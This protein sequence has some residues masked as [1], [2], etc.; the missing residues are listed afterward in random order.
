MQTHSFDFSDNS[1]RAGFRLAALEVLNWGTFHKKIWVATPGGDNSLLTGDIGSGKSTLVDGLTTLLVPSQKITYN[2]AAGAETK[3]RNLTSYVRG[4]YK[5]A[6]DDDTLSA[7]AVALRDHNSYSVLLARFVNEGFDQTITLAQVFWSRDN[8]NTP[9]RFYLVARTPLSIAKHFSGFGSDIGDLKK[10]LKRKEH[11]KLFDSFSQ[12]QAEFRRQMGIDNDQALELLYQTV[13]MKSVGN[14]TEFVRSHMLESTDAEEKVNELS[15]QFDNL[16]RAHEA[17]LK[18]RQQIDRLAPMIDN[19]NQYESIESSI[20]ALRQ[21][22]EALYGFFADKKITLLTERIQRREQEQQKLESRLQELRLSIDDLRTTSRELERAIDQNGG[23]RLSEL[24]TELERLARERNRIAKACDDYQALCNILEFSPPADDDGFFH[25]R[26]Q[27]ETGLQSLEKQQADL[28]NQQVEHRVEFQKLRSQHDE[29]EA[30]IASLKSRQSNIPSRNLAIR[31][32]LSESLNLPESTLPF[33]GELLQV[34]EEDK[35]WEGAVERVLHNFALSLLVPDEHYQSVADYVDRTHLKG[36]LVYYRVRQPARATADTLDPRSLCRKVSIKTDS[37]FYSWLEHELSQRFDYICCD[38]LEDF[39]REVRAITT[40]GQIKS[41]GSRHEKDDRYRIDDRSR[42]VLG[43]SNRE[44]IFTLEATRKQ[45]EA[46]IQKSASA[47]MQFNQQINQLNQR[48]LDLKLLLKYAD[49]AEINWQPLA[50]QINSLEQEKQQLETGSDI[51]RTLRERLERC[52]AATG[53]KEQQERKLTRESGTAA[54]K[55][56]QDHKLLK[57]SE[58]QLSE[59]PE[60]ARESCFPTLAEMEQEALGDKKITIENCDS[61]QSTMRSWL[62]H[63]LDSREKKSRELAARITG[64]MADYKNAYPQET[65]EVDASMGSVAEFTAMLETLQGEDLPRHEQRFKQMLNEG[66]IHNM[67]MFQNWLDHQQ[68]TIRD[69]IATINRSLA[70][71]DYS[72]GTYIRLVA[73]NHR[74]PEINQ[75]KIDLRNCLGDTLTADNSDDAYAENK[76]L[77]VKTI[78]ERFNGREGQSELDKRWTRKV[79]DVRNW[80]L[81]NASERYREDDSEKEFYS[82]AGGKSGGQKEKLA[83]TILAAALA[84][85]LGLEWGENHS[86]SFR[87]VMIDEAFGRGSDE[88]AR[89]GLEL[90]R[91][92]NLQ[93]LIV[94]PLQKIHVIEDYV[95]SVHFVHNQGG[96]HSMLRNLTIEQYRQEKQQEQERLLQETISQHRADAIS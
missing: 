88:S 21:S 90:F 31:Q 72:D 67:A 46:D 68:Q 47:E 70:A 58:Q 44:K 42:F 75:F 7:K 56:K 51:L 48:Q 3:E 37:Q 45:L 2:K 19:C 71:I 53:E 10:K 94:T 17:V 59:L 64:Q 79:T 24:K 96:N 55:L 9:E 28:Q 50:I 18:A 91:R 95:N 32:A 76:F 41:G 35:H 86:R 73:D 81:F 65:R 43:W 39:R 54:E 93:L 38:Q 84:Y 15:R 36:R 69:K 63:R 80:F 6:K 13:S 4:Y 85:Q 60:T 83:Y 20:A 49:F 22:R 40:A 1:K 61:S 26:Q 29:L 11:I 57:F 89:Y 16:N 33:A 27:A 14:L 77:Q 25:N 8:S 12:Y 78:V 5:S 30:E 82:D 52:E 92:L 23:Q 34:R 87:F 66:T 74:D 62:Q